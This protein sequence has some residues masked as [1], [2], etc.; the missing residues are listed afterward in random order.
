MLALPCC[1][2]LS[3]VAA[4]G[5]Y[6]LVVVRGL[7]LLW[8]KAPELRASVSAVLGLSSCSSWALEHRLNICSTQASLLH[9]LW[10]LPRPGKESKSSA[11]A[12][13]FFTTEPPEKPL[14]LLLLSDYHVS[15]TEAYRGM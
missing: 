7:L 11:L 4:S 14:L 12:G 5:G 9:G 10:D 3:I 13:G 8:I 15:E 6:S 2:G 1:S